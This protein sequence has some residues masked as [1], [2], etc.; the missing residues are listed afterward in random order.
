MRYGMMV[1]EAYEEEK[2]NI[3]EDIQGMSTEEKQ[4]KRVSQIKK[5]IDKLNLYL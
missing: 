3:D 2:P 4:E 1:E 5:D